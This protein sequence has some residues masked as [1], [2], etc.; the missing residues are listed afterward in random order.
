MHSPSTHVAS[1]PEVCFPVLH[2]PKLE[3]C[4]KDGTCLWLRQVSE[5]PLRRC[6]DFDGESLHVDLRKISPLLE[7]E[8]HQAAPRDQPGVIF[9][10]LRQKFKSA[11]AFIEAVQQLHGWRAPGRLAA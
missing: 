3:L 9:F 11:E 10:T 5:D 4:F 2:L 7:E 6:V 8:V 1:K